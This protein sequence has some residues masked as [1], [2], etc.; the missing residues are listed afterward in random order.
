MAFWI[1][2]QNN[3]QTV[4]HNSYRC[5]CSSLSTCSGLN[6]Y[7]HRV[8]WHKEFYS[9]IFL[10]NGFIYFLAA[11]QR[12]S[13]WK[14]GI[15]VGMLFY[16]VRAHF[17]PYLMSV[18]QN[19]FSLCSYVLLTAD[20]RYFGRK[21][22]CWVMIYCDDLSIE[23]NIL[24]MRANEMH[25]FSNLFDDVLYMFRTGPLSIM[26]SIS[27]LYTSYSCICHAGYVGVCR[28]STELT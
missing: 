17:I 21:M 28:Q 6:N 12:D 18:Y 4:L 10:A 13:F 9:N 1:I 24:I 8:I 25:Y 26:R 19:L 7:L 2:Q 16:R 23:W 20:G 5:S 3:T 14:R 22:L 11:L 27:T 15:L